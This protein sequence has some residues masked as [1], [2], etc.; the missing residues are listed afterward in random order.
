MSD[1][2]FKVVSVTVS[3]EVAENSFG[4]G[5]KRF[6][7]LRAET[8]AEAPATLN[9]ALLTSLDLHLAAF[10]SVYSSLVSSDR[11]PIENFN[12]IHSQFKR[13]I[14]KLRTALAQRSPVTQE[15]P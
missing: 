13:R 2:P 10:E 5:S 8:P 14:S 1:S 6:T 15:I 7:S 3:L 9:E 11:I 4:N 12:A